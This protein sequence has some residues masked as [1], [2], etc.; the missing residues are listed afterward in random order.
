MLQEQ[1][2]VDHHFVARLK[3]AANAH[4]AFVAAAA[5][6]RHQHRLAAELRRPGFHEDLLRTITQEHRLRRHVECAGRLAGN[7]GAHVHLGLQ[8]A[9]RVAQPGTHFQRVAGRVECIGHV[10]DFCVDGLLRPGAGA[11]AQALAGLQ[12]AD[13]AL[14]RVDPAPQIGRVADDEQRRGGLVGPPLHAG[15]DGAFDH[16]ARNRAAQRVALVD[17]VAGTQRLQTQAGALGFGARALQIALRLFEVLAGHDPGFGEV[18]RARQ[19][20]RGLLDIGLRPRRLGLRGPQL[21][22]RQVGQRLP[23]LHRGTRLHQRLDDAPGHRR[24]DACGVVFVP[25]QTGGQGGRVGRRRRHRLRHQ[26]LHFGCLD[27]EANGVV[28]NRGLGGHR[29]LG[30]LAASRNQTE[31]GCRHQRHQKSRAHPSA[32]ALAGYRQR[33][34]KTTISVERMHGESRSRWR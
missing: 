33:R 20:A 25:C 6:A 31:G 11:N 9:Q 16:R 21:R 8:V 15:V 13:G 3:T 18:F 17:H 1:R 27:R 32:P 22:R 26:P 19:V 10:I 7:L 4:P 23:G 29:G 14:G 34:K 12:G 2:T 24:D 28:G 5:A 30:S